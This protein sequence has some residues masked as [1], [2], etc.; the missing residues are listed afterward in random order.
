MG[1]NGGVPG[2]SGKTPKTGEDPKARLE[3]SVNALNSGQ[4]NNA[5]NYNAEVEKLKQYNQGNNSSANQVQRAEAIRQQASSASANKS[6]SDNYAKSVEQIKEYEPVRRLSPP[7]SSLSGGVASSAGGGA[8][9]VASASGTGTTTSAGAGTKSSGGGGNTLGDLAKAVGGR[10][11]GVALSNAV[12][13]LGLV[14]D[15]IMAAEIGGWVGGRLAKAWIDLDKKAK[16]KR[17]GG[18]YKALYSETSGNYTVA[19]PIY[20]FTGGQ[21]I[22]VAYKVNYQVL[23]YSY[24]PSNAYIEYAQ[25]VFAGKILEL[26][27]TRIELRDSDNNGVPITW[28]WNVYIKFENWALG[29]SGQIQESNSRIY[30]GVEVGNFSVERADGQ[31]DTG[32]NPPPTTPEITGTGSGIGVGSSVLNTGGYLKLQGSPSGT[33]V[34]LDGAPAPE[35]RNITVEDFG[36]GTFRAPQGYAPDWVFGS[37]TPPPLTNSKGVYVPVPEVE[38]TSSGGTQY[39]PSPNLG[40]FG[41][42][43]IWYDK[44][45]NVVTKEAAAASRAGIGFESDRTLTFV[46]DAN[47]NTRLGVDPSG[48]TAKSPPSTSPPATQ[49]SGTTGTDVPKPEAPGAQPTPVPVPVAP[50]PTTPEATPKFDLTK[51]MIDEIAIAVISIPAFIA[52]K[53]FASKAF[54]NTE[55]IKNTPKSPCLAPVY[56]PPV[57]ADVKKNLI[58]TNTLQGVTIAQGQVTQNAVNAVS[59]TV[60]TVNTKLGEQLVGGIGGTLG[61][62]FNSLGLDRWLN[63]INTAL[64]IHNATMLSN[65]VLQTVGS[66]VDNILQLTGFQFK[67]AEGNQVSFGELVGLEFHQLLNTVLGAQ[68]ATALLENLKKA[69][70]IYQAA[71]NVLWSVQSLLDSARSLTEIAIENTGKIGNALRK[72]GAV[73]E[74]AY[75]P[76]VEKATASSASQQKFDNIVNNLDDVERVFSTFEQITSEGVSIKDNLQQIKTDK[77]EFDDSIKAYKDGEKAKEDASKTTSST[78]DITKIHLVK[79]EETTP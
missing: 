40:D 21:S 63:L 3:R 4:K 44:D 51:T 34:S 33:S 67:N 42:G 48:S 64:L 31:P 13:G 66:V 10:V 73:F 27:A 70:R 25:L 65:N 74:N 54:Q 6:I 78:V 58:A 35:P 5:A 29:A 32:G 22:G 69:N 62:L 14:N 18:E 9:G 75:R 60:N 55:A 76:M 36:A 49:P 47:G 30:R 50:P 46:T 52:L 38:P 79:P 68:N 23:R 26:R 53:D 71:A 12:P 39:L 15:V 45:G 24:Y 19:P 37:G 28:D 17:T 16:A 72:A 61:R 59:T 56:V 20:P 2:V 77:K 43:E 8:R 1:A 7:P 57:G 41:G 11:A